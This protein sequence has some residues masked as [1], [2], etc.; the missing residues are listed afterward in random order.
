[1]VL[2]A[3]YGGYQDDLIKK[4]NLRYVKVI[5]SQY[6]ARKLHLP[7]D[8][9]DTHAANPDNRKQSFALLIHGIQPKGSKASVALEK[10]KK[11]GWKGYGKTK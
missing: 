8:H 10:L 2:T 11:K 3:S 6:E 9:D 1:M 5:Y 4:H 7:I